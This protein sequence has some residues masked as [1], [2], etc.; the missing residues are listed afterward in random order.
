MISSELVARLRAETGGGV[1]DC[2]K[3]LEKTGGDFEKAKQIL[4]SHAQ[5]IAQKKQERSVK[6]GLIEC[7]CHSGKIGVVLELNCETDFVA[8]N[9][10]FKTLAKDLAMQIASMNPKNL[11]DLLASNFIKD[12][13][14]TVQA[15]IEQAVA[16]TG[17][18]IQ[19]KRFVRYELG[20]EN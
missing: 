1:M 19:I 15:L 9:A 5:V 7:Y 3:A 17:E 13:S 8:R 14:S 6:Q 2:K 12:E 16:K 11:E 18:N 20:E 4:V 10:E